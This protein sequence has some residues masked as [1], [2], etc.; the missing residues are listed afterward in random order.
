MTLMPDD[1]QSSNLIFHEGLPDKQKIEEFTQDTQHS[2]IVLDD[3][4]SKVVQSEE[5]LHLFAVTSHHKKASVVLISQS[6]YP[7]G[8]Y[9]KSISLNCAN[10]VLFHNP[11]DMRQIVTFASQILPGMT[12]YFL[13]AFLKIT[14]QKYAYILIDLS[15]H[16]E[17]RQYMLR[18]GIFPEDKQDKPTGEIMENE[19]G[20]KP[21]ISK[22]IEQVPNSDPAEMGRF[23]EKINDDASGTP[24]ILDQPPKKMKRKNMKKNLKWILY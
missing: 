18:T 11:R 5:V 22:P 15:P 21:Q 17:D 20:E 19:H 10:F 8:K 7:P 16:R 14:K 13:D 23:V 3:L 1:I 12:R 6:L 24:G 9:S 2:L 4:I